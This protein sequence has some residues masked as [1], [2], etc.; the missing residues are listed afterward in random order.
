MKDKNKIKSKQEM[1]LTFSIIY[2]SV[3]S[4]RQGI[5]AAK[6]LERK[7]R[8]RDITTHFIDPMEYHLPL[9]DKMY[10]EYAKDTAPAVMETLAVCLQVI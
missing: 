4:D 5:K 2:G 3:R 7:L 1:K 8:E 10:K 6:F 9:L